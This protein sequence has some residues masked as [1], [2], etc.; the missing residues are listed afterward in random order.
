MEIPSASEIG[1]PLPGVSA[2]L[3]LRGR[4]FSHTNLSGEGEPELHPTVQK[5][6][7]ELPV[8]LREAYV[9]HCAESALVSDQ[10][11]GLDRGRTD[12]RATTL[13]EA[14]GQLAG[15]S[16]MAVKVRD[17]GRTPQAH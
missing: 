4:V 11:W 16:I 1:S 12:G 15:A 10:L 14:K 2:S 17:H 7:D 6:F 8:H 9:G 5:F 3:L 13:D